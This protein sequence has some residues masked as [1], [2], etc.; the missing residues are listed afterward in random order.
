MESKPSLKTY[1]YGRMRDGSSPFQVSFAPIPKSLRRLVDVI[2]TIREGC[3]APAYSRAPEGVA[4][5]VC[6]VTR[7]RSGPVG[8]DV[9][10]A[11]LFAAGPHVNRIPM[12]LGCET[13][14]A[15]LR[16]GSLKAI[17][18][19]S[20]E[21]LEGQSVPASTLLGA[22]GDEALER[23]AL[24]SSASARLA[25]VMGFIERRAEQAEQRDDLFAL[26]AAAWMRSRPD[27]LSLPALTARCGYSDRQI[28][29][30]FQ[31]SLGLSP[32]EYARTLRLRSVLLRGTARAN[33]AEIAASAG[34]YDQAHLVDDFKT[35]L[36]V[37]PGAFFKRPDLSSLSTMGIVQDDDP[38]I[39]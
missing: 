11:V 18:G 20:A 5:L 13:L 37:P 4:H 7:W 28:R 29:R 10:A 31:E 23:I 39:P 2:L 26:T 36:G 6:H 9:G 17:L 14:V 38:V 27:T 25:A 33:W 34:Y 15:Q 30:K 8:R 3:D 16:P 24:A 22:A 21:Y 35:A 19:V 1:N 12:P 32:K